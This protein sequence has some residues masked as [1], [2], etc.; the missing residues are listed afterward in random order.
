MLER[1]LGRRGS[2]AHTEAIC[3][4][5][6]AD[7]DVRVRWRGEA[8]DR[9]LDEAHAGLVERMV[10]VLE[11]SGWVTAVEV[12]FS[13]FG[14]R[15]SIDI[16][17]WHGAPRTLLVVE[18]KSVIPDAQ[19]TL[20]PLDRKTRL[21]RKIGRDRGWDARSISRL[22]VVGD[23]SMNRRRVARLESTFRG[24]VSSPRRRRSSVAS[25]ARGLDVG[26]AIP[27]GS[28]AG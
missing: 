6:G 10:R 23:G 14:E 28:S 18:I 3:E 26:A 4:V 8:L 1:G 24:G 7:L 2:L 11:A 9:L 19:A 16:L 15:G 22:L 27:V 17:G 12:T 25:P 13:E 5:L 21:A 20:S